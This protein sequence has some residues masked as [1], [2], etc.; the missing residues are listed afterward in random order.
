MKYIL[1][2]V[3]LSLFFVVGCS[4]PSW[5]EREIRQ[6]RRDDIDCVPVVYIR[7]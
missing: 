1:I 4:I 3:F 5:S 2:V 6:M 7:F